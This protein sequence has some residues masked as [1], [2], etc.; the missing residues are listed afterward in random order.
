MTVYKGKGESYF[1]TM[2]TYFKLA[3]DHLAVAQTTVDKFVYPNS[4]QPLIDVDVKYTT[5]ENGKRKWDGY[6]QA[7]ANE[8]CPTM[9]KK[10]NDA[11][12]DKGGTILYRGTLSETASSSV[13]RIGQ[14]LYEGI[15][16]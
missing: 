12:K 9:F 1:D 2:A 5:D 6:K 15:T 10:Y 16:S 4:K 13:R 11:V 14:K 8:W 3:L 7:P